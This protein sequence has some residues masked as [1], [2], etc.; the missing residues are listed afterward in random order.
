ML[1][2]M[3]LSLSRNGQRSLERFAA[4]T[5]AKGLWFEP[6]QG[7]AYSNPGYMLLKRVAEEV[8]GASY[9]TLI[10]ERIAGRLGLQRTFVAESIEDLAA[11]AP[12]TSS[13]LSPDGAPRDVRVLYHPGWVS[14][15]VLASTASDL[16]CFL[17]GL[18]HGDLLSRSSLAPMTEL[19]VVPDPADSSRV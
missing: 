16:V 8:A 12:G 15:G 11:L 5:F 6:G 1:K 3:K 14:H 2:T 7:W 4:E 18:F 17:D 9:R 10:A 13:A 19:V